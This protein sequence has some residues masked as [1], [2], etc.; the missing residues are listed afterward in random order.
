MNSSKICWLFFCCV[1]P[2]G[3]VGCENALNDK[4]RTQKNSNAEQIIKRG[5]PGLAIKLDNTQPIYI[6]SIGATTLELSLVT[7]LTSGT[8]EVAVSTGEPLDLLSS[9]HYE[10]SLDQKANYILP[11]QISAA[12]EGRFYINLA[13]TI[14]N[15]DEREHRSLAVIVQV[16]APKL[17]AAQKTGAASEPE[18]IEMPA[19]ETIKSAQ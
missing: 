4:T 9:S 6:E 15:G 8:M 16:G 18:I 3:L 19:Q 13:I 14:S 1:F 5:K 7:P 11:L 2:I 17:K 10:F 12:E